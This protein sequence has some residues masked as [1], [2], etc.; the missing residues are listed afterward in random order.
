MFSQ[1]SLPPDSTLDLRGDSP[2]KVNDVMWSKLGNLIASSLSPIMH[3]L[4]KIEEGL[5]DFE[6]KVMNNLSNLEGFLASRN[7]LMVNTSNEL[8]NVVLGNSI[9]PKSL[10]A[11]Q[12]PSTSS[13]PGMNEDVVGNHDV[14]LVHVGVKRVE[15]GVNLSGPTQAS[16]CS[17]EGEE[18]GP[19]VGTVGDKAPSLISGPQRRKPQQTFEGVDNS[20]AL[21]GSQVL[22]L[23]PAAAPLAVILRNIPVSQ[24][25][26]LETTDQLMAKTM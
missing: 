7:R 17:Q 13:V 16:F 2:D 14:G 5:T 4:S 22:H 21:E 10:V 15:Q 6:L 26:Q 8:S 24:E 11:R 19:C 3:R 1:P 23:P 25:G 9:P 12:I 18:S 20:I